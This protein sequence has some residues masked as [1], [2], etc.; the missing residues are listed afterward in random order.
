MDIRKKKI[1]NWAQTYS[2]TCQVIKLKNQNELSEALNFI[3]KKKLNFSIMSS[4]KNYTDEVFCSKGYIIDITNLNKILEFN[5]NQKTI[6]VEAA[7]TLKKLLKIII[8]YNYTIGAIPGSE[9]ISIGGA[10][11]N[12]VHGKD[13]KYFGCF[14]ENINEI[15]IIK[16]NGQEVVL[17]K[18]EIPKILTFGVFYIIKKIKL[19]LIDIKCNFVNS[20]KIIFNDLDEMTQIMSKNNDTF[21]YG[22]MDLNSKKIRGYVEIGNIEKNIQIQQKKNTGVLN[23]IVRYLSNFFSNFI[24]FSLNKYTL[25]IINLSIYYSAKLNNEKI[26][27][28]Y[29]Y[30]FPLKRFPFEKFFRGGVV[31]I[32]ILIPEK[33]LKNELINIMN[34]CGLYKIC[35]YITG[36]KYQKDQDIDL[37]FYKKGLSISIVIP[38][39]K[40][41]SLNFKYFK[42]KLSKLIAEKKIYLNL[43]KDIVFDKNIIDQNDKVNFIKNKKI[44]DVEG[45]IKSDFIDRYELNYEI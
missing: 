14:V 4:N 23:L 30:Y 27:S 15:T 34:L 11:T 18:N 19:N 3:N 17:K 1:S 7:C 35:S 41:R 42:E 26:I 28:L 8:P 5:Y 38:K 31:E 40:A 24:K 33:N 16:S 29:D 2:K 6:V 25:K 36:L 39:H 22:W 43:T 45:I 37:G 32:Q 21:M 12:C 10:V 20:K 9:D 44:Y 13:A